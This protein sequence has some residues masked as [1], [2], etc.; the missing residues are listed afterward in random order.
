MHIYSFRLDQDAAIVNVRRN[1][2]PDQMQPRLEQLTCGRETQNG[3]EL[4]LR[5]DQ[6]AET[7]PSPLPWIWPARHAPRASAQH[8]AIQRCFSAP[9]GSPGCLDPGHRCLP[10]LAATVHIEVDASGRKRAES[11]PSCCRDRA[12]KYH[13]MVTKG[14]GVGR[15]ESGVRKAD[16]EPRTFEY[17]ACQYLSWFN[18]KSE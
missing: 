11:R 4:L 2:H 18:Q 16:R 12:L 8:P 5:E 7:P 9:T 13:D 15:A 14:C 10:V 1:G 6:L 17:H 3:S